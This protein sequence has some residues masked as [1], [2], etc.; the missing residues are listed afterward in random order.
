M[1]E[2]IEKGKTDPKFQEIVYEITRGAGNKNYRG[3]IERIFRWAKSN[4]RYTRDPYGVEMVQDVF[5]TLKRGRADCDDF[6]ILIGAAAEVMGAPV[7][8]TTVSTRAD[9]E[10]VHVYPEALIG[11]RWLALDATVPSSTPGWRPS[12]G[13]TDRIV[14]TRKDVGIHGYDEA[15]VEG[16]GMAELPWKGSMIPVDVTPGVPSD[17]SHTYASMMPGSQVAAARRQPGDPEAMIARYSD[18]T[19]NPAPGDL[20]YNPSLPIRPFPMPNQ[21]WSRRPRESI[22]MK[23]D[24]WGHMR[25]WQKDPSA[26]LPQPNVAEENYMSNVAGVYGLNLAGISEGEAKSVVGA[27]HRDVARQVSAGVIS[28][29][30]AVNRAKKIVDAV[31]SGDL[32]TVRKNPETFRSVVAIAKARGPRVGGAFSEPSMSWIPREGG[33]A[34]LSGFDGLEL[35]DI[36]QSDLGQLADAIG[37]DIAQQVSSGALPPKAAAVAAGKAVDAIKTGDTKILQS[38]PR[39]AAVVRRIM[40]RRSGAPGEARTPATKPHHPISSNTVRKSESRMRDTSTAYF[41]EDESLE[42]MPALYGLSGN[43]KPNPELLRRVQEAVRKRLPGELRRRGLRGRSR[44]NGLGDLGDD[45]T[46]QEAAAASSLASTIASTIS[47]AVA[48][49]D[50]AAITKAVNAGVDAALSVVTPQRVPMAPVPGT[51]ADRLKGWG[52][53]TLVVAGILGVAFLMK[54]RKSRY[55]SN[56]RRRSRSRRGGGGLMTQKN[57]LIALGVGAAYIALKKPAAAPMVTSAGAAPVAD[58]SLAQRLLSSVANLFKA[59]SAP[60]PATQAAQIMT[61]AGGLTKSLMPIFAPAPAPAPAPTQP[62]SSWE[63][64][65]VTDLSTPIAQNGSAS[66]WEQNVVTEL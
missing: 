54:K 34:G 19:E 40:G 3:E 60:P 52:P 25:P 38:T 10:P 23:I 39:T 28:K 43:R 64:T 2:L 36:D 56:P 66:S 20:P 51:I 12:S 49:S 24:P 17:V 31:T 1:Y 59:P 21:I 18:L 47:G 45:L 57:M 46:A 5:S 37:K 29:Q 11:G 53:T 50:S 62:S 8:I 65:A 4:I 30:G 14:W 63:S 22:P 48:P 16:L 55:Q 35:G 6:T 7:R 15:H 41:E 44:M 27:I 42:W 13:I 32:S 9:R 58:Q 61:A 26:M 33:V